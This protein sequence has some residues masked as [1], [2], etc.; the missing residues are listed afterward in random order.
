MPGAEAGAVLLKV[1]VAVVERVAPGGLALFKSW[2][3]GK[4][5]M[6]VGQARAGKTTFIDYLQYGFLKTRKRR[7][8]RQSSRAA[9]A[10]IS[11]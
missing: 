9:R 2:L 8:R 11:S 3:K 1:G 4:E 6:I 10:L 7:P 5:V